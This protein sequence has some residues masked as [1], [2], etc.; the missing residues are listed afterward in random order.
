MDAQS[1]HNR[2]TNGFYMIKDR[3]V[4][5]HDWALHPMLWHILV[6][7][8]PWLNSCIRKNKYLYCL[9]YKHTF[10]RLFITDT[11]SL[12][13][14]LSDL[15]NCR[16]AVGNWMLLLEILPLYCYLSCTGAVTDVNLNVSSLVHCIQYQLTTVVV[17][18]AVSS[19]GAYNAP[20]RA[21][22][23]V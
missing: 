19:S 17:S 1:I 3:I 11:E 14:R 7:F 23:S 12:S 6:C 20:Q 21:Q 8:N 9:E 15:F 22:T 16:R 5:Q 4:Q 13:D 2:I 10:W 18:C